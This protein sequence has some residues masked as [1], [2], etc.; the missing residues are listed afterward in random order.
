MS[1]RMEYTTQAQAQAKADAIH[2]W[3]IANRPAYAASVSQG[4]TLRWAIPYLTAFWNVN[5]KDRSYDSL[6]VPEKASAKAITREIL[7]EDSAILNAELGGEL[8]P[9]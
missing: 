3:M 6:S 2:A 4:Q 7:A 5:V 1:W 9:E 8:N